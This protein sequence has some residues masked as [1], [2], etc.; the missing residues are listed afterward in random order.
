[1]CG[2]FGFAAGSRNNL[3]QKFITSSLSDLF[4]L[5]ESRGKEASGLAFLNHE[6]IYIH[7]DALPGSRMILTSQ[8]KRLVNSA[9]RQACQGKGFPNP[10]LAVIGHSRL[11]TN[12]LQG[13]DTNNQPVAKKCTVVVHNGIVVNIDKL[14]SEFPYL[15]RTTDVDTEIIAELV[16]MYR[17]KGNS[18]EEA[19]C[20]TLANIQGEASVAILF[21]DIN[22]MVLATNTGSIFTHYDP[23]H[24]TIFFASEAYIL[25]QLFQKNNNFSHFDQN[26]I[27]QVKAGN[28]LLINLETLEQHSFYLNPDQLPNL[29]VNYLLP[30]IKL[31]EEKTKRY[32]ENRARL[33][34][35][36]KCI[37]PETM[38][39]IEFDQ[40][41]VCNYCRNYK[42]IKTLGYDPL[43]AILKQYR[44]KN[45][46]PDCLVAFSG[47]RDSSYGLHLLKTE[48][49]MNPIAYTYDWG[50]VTDLGRRNQARL[51]GKLGIEHIWVSADIKEKRANIRRNIEAWMRRPDIG[52]VPLFMAGDKQFF[53]YANQ[54]MKQ[55][56]IKLMIFCPNKMEKTDFKTG[57]CGVPPHY[58]ENQPFALGTTQK[59]KL[60]TYYGSQY[61]LNPAYFNRSLIDTIFAYTSL[62]L[63]KTNYIYI[64]DFL[65][66][67]ERIINKTLINE[68]DWETAQDTT[69]T[70]RIGDG[71]AAFYNYIYYTVVGFTEFDTFRSNQIREGTLSREEA[72]QLVQAENQ[73]RWNSIREYT[74]LIGLDFDEV[75]QVINNLPRFYNT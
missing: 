10:P 63:I 48:F 73:P 55:T 11:V 21:S 1:M 51:C 16:Q 52:M 2:V 34:R 58:E 15:D 54:T 65:P 22:C 64:Y 74:Q 61:L 59:I 30:K 6:K 49:G 25:R 7:K 24:D 69:T 42:K 32:E 17:D 60:A 9:L 12:G 5:S 35:C 56:G 68:Y 47:G 28:G 44:S 31:I 66:W 57:F 70:W 27:S 38:P 33:R 20:K 71:T 72:L 43:E 39:F 36:T 50:M 26:R 18:V 46:E 41:G 53:Y 40:H 29:H 19:I 23:K 8:Y 3:H 14:W 67:D 37:L 62:Y 13:I 45:G 75:M 4:R